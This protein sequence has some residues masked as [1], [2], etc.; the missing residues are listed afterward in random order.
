MSTPHFFAVVIPAR[1]EAELLG[2]CLDAVAHAARVA[3][4][5]YGRWMPRVEVVVAADGCTDAT[6]DIAWNAGVGVVELPSVGVGAARST[7]VHRALRNARPP[8]DDIWIANTDADSVV[9]ASWIVDQIEFARQGVD[10]VIGSVR[11][12]F[13][14]LTP[15]QKRAWLATHT[16]GVANGHVHGANLGVRASAYVNSGGFLPHREHE[17]NDLVR[18]LIAAGATV[19]ASSSS[20]V[21]TSGRQFGRTPGGYA[22]YLREQ[23]VALAEQRELEGETEELGA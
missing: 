23:L 17:D 5:K 9:P 22:G 18:R 13:E 1:D 7:G 11:P 3:R 2:R 10:V 12:D 15:L 16:P 8:L 19:V 6:A 14:D 4:R 20:E 21:V